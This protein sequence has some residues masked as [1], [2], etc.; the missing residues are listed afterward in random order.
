MLPPNYI[1]VQKWPHIEGLQLA[2]PQFFKSAKID[3][4][5]A[6]DVYWAAMLEGIRKGPLGTPL[7]QNTEFGWIL[8]GLVSESSN[9]AKRF[10]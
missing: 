9:A 6:A 1:K 10:G 3:I 2:D 8:S 7:A 5:L 4:V